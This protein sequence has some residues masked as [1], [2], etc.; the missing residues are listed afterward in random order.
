MDRES[1]IIMSS[2]LLWI[3]ILGYIL[4]TV[5]LARRLAGIPSEERSGATS[6]LAPGTVAPKLS[7]IEVQS[8]N[9]L[10][11]KSW[12]DQRLLLVFLGYQCAPCIALIPELNR[13]LKGTAAR[14]DVT[15]LPI[16]IGP[17][18]EIRSGYFN[19]LESPVYIDGADGLQIEQE[20]QLF[21]TPSY[22]LIAPTGEVQASGIA[23]RVDKG[24][25]GM[26]QSWSIRDN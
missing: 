18:N 26:V 25:A 20:F 8:G 2:V 21:G 10:D 19:D 22:C 17:G 4:F 6:G 16:A 7:L 23:S 13:L 12:Q 1:V 14:W 5:G 15:I 9:H 11:S 24:W 3:M